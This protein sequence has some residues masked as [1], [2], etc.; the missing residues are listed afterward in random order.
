M[1]GT[2]YS[3]LNYTQQ[4]AYF[5]IDENFINDKDSKILSIE[6]FQKGFLEDKDKMSL[7][8]IFV[9]NI[10]IK[11][12]KEISLEK[13]NTHS[14]RIS[15][16]YG[17]AIYKKSDTLSLIANIVLKN[18]IT[19]LENT[20]FYWG[21]EDIFVNQTHIKY[22]KYLGSGW[23]FLG[24]EKELKLTGETVPVSTKFKC[25]AVYEE[26]N[27]LEDEILIRVPSMEGQ[28]NSEIKINSSAGQYFYNGEGNTKLTVETSNLI[29]PLSYQW[30]KIDNLKNTVY[31]SN[32]ESI[33]VSAKDINRSVVYKCGV[34]DANDV[35]QGTASLEIYNLT[36]AD[37]KNI[38]LYNGN[39]TFLYDLTGK[40]PCLE[41]NAVKQVIL[42]LSFDYYDDTGKK[43]PKNRLS[44]SWKI[45]KKN[46][47]LKGFLA[48]KEVQ[49]GD[50]N[51]YILKTH[52]ENVSFVLQDF[53]SANYLDNDIILE[54]VNEE[55][56]DKKS[57]ITTNF[58]FLKQGES[59]TNG[60][61]IY[62]VIDLKI[63]D[64]NGVH[65][66]LSDYAY[67]TL[68]IFE[69]DN[70]ATLNNYPLTNNPYFE[71]S[72]YQNGEVLSDYEVEWSIVKDV[73]DSNSNVSGYFTFLNK[74]GNTTQIENVNVE[75]NIEV[76]SGNVEIE[77]ND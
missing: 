75:G 52:D 15:Y 9:K 7:I 66:I 12:V 64:E 41:G 47:M 18:N 16:P 38:S 45:P 73:K 13:Y 70:Y 1:S 53:Y 77:S 26:T 63:N 42:P 56:S 44:I 10:S 27:V 4:K 6:L 40:S 20:K 22:N 76:E 61:N 69:V 8:D 50:E 30:V 32:E 54:V 74:N 49:E 11:G 28:P 36:R 3:L 55:T 51:Y 48:E 58:T 33:E 24:N 23:S 17:D 37:N 62:G 43:V 25:V 46:S 60:T 14:L 29:A 2:P 68:E 21:K 5:E 31:L 19:S 71:A 67:P 57:V 39:Q 72:L 35:V 34:K 59:G 65:S